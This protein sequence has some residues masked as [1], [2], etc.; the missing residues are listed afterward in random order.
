[1]LMKYDNEEFEEKDVEE[2]NCIFPSQLYSCFRTQVELWLIFKVC[3][4][5]PLFKLVKCSMQK[6]TANMFLLFG[7]A[8]TFGLLKMIEGC[9]L[10]GFLWHF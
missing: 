8:A 9:V 3:Y 5:L 1:M 10:Q 7:G 4:V 2:G 6:A